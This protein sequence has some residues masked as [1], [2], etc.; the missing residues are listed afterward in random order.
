MDPAGAL[1]AVCCS[2]HCLAHLNA[3][4]G[5]RVQRLADVRLSAHGG[6]RFAA[7]RSPSVTAE[8]PFDPRAPTP[9]RRPAR[10][11]RLLQWLRQPAASVASRHRRSRS[12]GRERRRPIP[13]PRSPVAGCRPDHAGRVGERRRCRGRGPELGRRERIHLQPARAAPRP[14]RALHRQRAVDRRSRPSWG[15]PRSCGPS[16]RSRAGAVSAAPPG[17]SSGTYSASR[18]TTGCGH[19]RPIDSMPHAGL[20]PRTSGPR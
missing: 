18:P 17:N 16:R 14:G 13:L 19:P 3:A 15:T 12:A 11:A 4:P 10:H 7:C 1:L 2:R 5:R 8:V 9:L 20:G 6:F